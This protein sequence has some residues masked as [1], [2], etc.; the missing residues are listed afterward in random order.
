MPERAK[1]D[2]MTQRDV[3]VA[4]HRFQTA[5][6][7]IVAAKIKTKLWL[8]IDGRFIIGDGG[9][10]LLEGIVSGGSLAEAVRAIGWSYRHA[11]GYLRSAETLLE[12]PLVRARPGRGAARGMILTEAGHLLLE[13]LR[14]L[15]ERIDATVGPS[16]PTARDVA[17]RGREV[18]RRR[19]RRRLRS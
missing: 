18:A 13:R 3:T 15:R 7:N 14:E 9:L 16:G 11:W 1:V 2:P 4:A 6:E 8:E 5:H 17:V 19:P 10:H 12:T